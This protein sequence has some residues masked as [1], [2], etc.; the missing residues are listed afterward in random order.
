MPNHNTVEV[1]FTTKGGEKVVAASDKTGKSLKGLN[2]DASSA[3]GGMTG[4]GSSSEMVA[5]ALAALPQAIA[6][7]ALAKLST[8]IYSVNKEFGQY[9]AQLVTM[10][11]S[12]KNADAAFAKLTKFAANTPYQLG[13]VV[14]AF[15]KLKARGLDPSEA[16]LTSYGN[17]ASGMSKSL[18]Q[19]IEA[20]GDAASGEF[21]RL[22][23]FGITASSEGKKVTFTF[24]GISTTI[25]KEASAIEAYLTRLGN[26]EFASGMTRQMEE[27]GGVASNFGDNWDKLMLSMGNAGGVTIMKDSISLVGQGLQGWSMALD[28]ATA[29]IKATADVMAAYSLG[30]ITYWEVLTLHTD[31]MR[32]KIRELKDEMDGFDP[33]AM[34]PS[35]DPEATAKNIAK[36]IADAEKAEAAR[37][38]A[39]AD[40][41]K[42]AHDE[43]AA[44]AKEMWIDDITARRE[45]MIALEELF[46]PDAKA[47]ERVAAALKESEALIAIDAERAVR[48]A[49]IRNAATEAQVQSE[50][51]KATRLGEIWW[52]NAQTYIGFAQSMS[53]MG[54][55]YALADEEQRG[56][57]AQRM[58]GTTIRFLSQSLAAYFFNKS[59]EQIFAAAGSASQIAAMGTVAAADMALGATRATAWAAY[60]AA[61]AANPIGAVAYGASAIA[62]GVAAGGFGVAGTTSAAIA[63]AGVSSNLL[64]AAGYA[65]AGIA[66]T[67]LGEAAA[68]KAEGTLSGNGQGVY[69]SGSPN[70]PTVVI[71]G[72]ST[73]ENTPA[74]IYNIYFQGYTD[75]RDP[76][77][78]ARLISGELRKAAGDGY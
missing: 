67:A 35:H 47:D 61:H 45:E 56:Q 77:D 42:K 26:T 34:L 18:D 1:E 48:Q 12:Q 7:I 37:A 69:G 11:G 51:D 15:S 21:E 75:A 53:T 2:K 5:S 31:E 10:T 3:A 29:E 74:K 63:A 24:K 65:A 70:S 76:A 28:D 72:S 17:T 22:K 30:Q 9:N 27:L 38:K 64:A 50:I 58:L 78:L 62:M 66:V 49:E 52:S 44:I 4:L 25:N 59:K 68:G 20:V 33:T 55:Q 43:A 8:D 16:A 60:Y 19:M 39:V 6:M 36:I 13:E 73:N 41:R 14:T 46:L 54:A 32:T 57:I 40:A 23:D 71:P